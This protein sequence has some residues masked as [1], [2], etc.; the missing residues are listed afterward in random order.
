M[1]L[2]SGL[3]DYLVDIKNYFSLL[4]IIKKNKSTLEWQ[5]LN[6]RVDWIGRIYTVINLQKEDFGETEEVR[7]IKIN[8]R[9]AIPIYTYLTERLNLVELLKTRL[10]YIEGT[11]SYLLYFVPEFT[12]LSIWST[13]KYFI[14]FYFLYVIL[15][16]FNLGFWFDKFIQYLVSINIIK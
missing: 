3:R 15:S 8:K 6:L 5:E 16:Y 2:L 1:I 13:I 11:Y 12:K 10:R 7:R 14:I 9:L 4:M